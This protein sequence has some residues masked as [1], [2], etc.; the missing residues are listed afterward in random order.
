MKPTTSALLAVSTMMGVGVSAM[1]RAMPEKPSASGMLRSMVM[2]S[3]LSSRASRAAALPSAATATTSK[4]GSAPIT[5]DSTS[6]K[7][8]ESSATS[9]RMRVSFLRHAETP[10]SRSSAPASVSASSSP[11]TM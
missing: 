11:L 10:Q 1:I 4:P 9:T 7:S 5:R 3:G 2:T 8:S 6:R